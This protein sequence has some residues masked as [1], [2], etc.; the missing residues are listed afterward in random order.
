LPCADALHAGAAALRN[1]VVLFRHCLFSKPVSAAAF[2]L[3]RMLCVAF[4]TLDDLLQHIAAAF[5][6]R[7]LR[8]AA[9][10]LRRAR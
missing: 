5:V 4:T 6:F 2:I 10:V 1:T 7:I 9:W 3:L 8:M